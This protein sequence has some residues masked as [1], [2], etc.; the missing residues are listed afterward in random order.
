MSEIG[1]RVVWQRKQLAERET[2]GRVFPRKYTF[3]TLCLIHYNGPDDIS[4]KYKRVVAK[5]IALQ[6]D[7]T[8]LKIRS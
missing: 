1:G 5:L 8:P 4:C 7:A 6:I 3:T 2:V